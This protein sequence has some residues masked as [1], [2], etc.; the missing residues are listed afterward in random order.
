MSAESLGICDAVALTSDGTL[1]CV[2]LVEDC[3][4]RIE[5][6]EPA[7]Q[8][9]AFFN[10]DGVRRQAAALDDLRRS[11]KTTGSLHGIPIG[12]KD[13]IDTALIPTEFGSELFSGRLPKSDAVLVERLKAAGAIIMGKT[14]TAKMATFMPGKT[15][16]PHNPNH[17]PGGSS[18]GSAA[19]VAAFMAAGAVGTQTNGSVIRP[20]SYCGTVGYKPSYGLIPRSGILTQSPFLDQVGV[21]ARSVNDAALL[22]EVM[23]GGDPAD[24]SSLGG[25]TTPALHQICTS[26]PPLPPKFGMVKTAIW[27]QADQTTRVGFEELQDVLGGQIELV[28]LPKNFDTVWDHLKT[29]NEAEMAAWYR[30]FYEHGPEF[31]DDV[32]SAQIERGRKISAPEYIAAMQYRSQLNAILDRVFN[33]YD[34]LITPAAAGAAPASLDHTGSPAF[35]TTWTYCGVPAV[36]LPLLTAEDNMPVGVQLIGSCLDDGRLLRCARWLS[37]FLTSQRD[38]N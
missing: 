25:Q 23:M 30:P 21:F 3:I 13:I 2:E 34:A 19:A 26:E 4:R 9:W 15:T 11:G 7:I 6:Y 38:Q 36:T 14:V 1:G 31:F 22:A 5:Q 33:N 37:E 18:S 29:V 27:D 28:E 35:C 12:I 20:A 17:T 10:P 8:A 24:K 16:N 32:V